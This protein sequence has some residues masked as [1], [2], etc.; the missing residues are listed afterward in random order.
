MCSK[1]TRL[2]SKFIGEMAEKDVILR[3]L[4]N[5][6]P[7]YCFRV[8]ID[9]LP[10]EYV[11]LSASQDCPL[12]R[13][14]SLIIGPRRQDYSNHLVTMTADEYNNL[15]RRRSGFTND[16]RMMAWRNY[17]IDKKLMWKMTKIVF[18]QIA[19]RHIEASYLPNEPTFKAQSLKF[20]GRAV[21]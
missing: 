15:I 21:A 8:G 13:M 12:D 6:M 9:N 2:Y 4:S 19:G 3:C 1:M 17:I 10:R 7:T 18:E 16:G 11:S 14:V 20:T 5:V